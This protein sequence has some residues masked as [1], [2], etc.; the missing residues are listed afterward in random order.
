[1]NFRT[2]SSAGEL[3]ELDAR[4]RNRR[5]GRNELLRPV[6]SERTGPALAVAGGPRRCPGHGRGRTGRRSTPMRR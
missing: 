1:M 2:D 6:E 5:Y 3:S 4:E